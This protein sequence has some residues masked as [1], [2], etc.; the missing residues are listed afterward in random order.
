[1]S[2]PGRSPDPDE[3]RDLPARFWQTGDLTAFME[4][5]SPF[6]LRYSRKRFCQDDDLIG[7]FYVHFYE[8]AVGCL[9]HYQERQ[10]IPFTGYLAKYLYNEFLNYIRTRRSHS[11]RETPAAEIYA[12]A[13]P[14]PDEADA[15]GA[16]PEIDLRLDRALQNL[17][18]R[19]RLPLKLYYG[20]ELNIEE[21]R[22]IVERLNDPVAASNF[23]IDYR[24]RRLRQS[25]RMRWLEDRAAHLTYLIHRSPGSGQYR[26]WTR[27]KERLRRMV[28]QNRGILSVGELSQLLGA[29]KSTIA[30]RIEQAQSQIR[31]AEN[32][33][34]SI[35]E[36]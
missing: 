29:S 3:L 18:V 17:P 19:L 36:V 31:G 15:T 34:P 16:P 32:D 23:L 2:Y 22:A 30:R 6:I 12:C 26:N 21:L 20:L 10:H 25:E 7:D 28:Q 8:R 14:D 11:Q 33:E 9:N 24:A 1:M 35:F 5:A 4:G 13:R 27:W